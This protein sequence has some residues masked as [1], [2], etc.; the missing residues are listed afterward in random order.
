[1]AYSCHIGC[2]YLM[3]MNH[4]TSTVSGELNVVVA[5]VLTICRRYSGFCRTG[6]KTYWLYSKHANLKL[7]AIKVVVEMKDEFA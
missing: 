5:A 3:V 7:G 2:G 4:R 6:L 1:M